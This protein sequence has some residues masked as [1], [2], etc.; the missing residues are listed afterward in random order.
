MKSYRLIRLL[1][2]IVAV[3]I[4]A[5]ASAFAACSDPGS[6]L[7]ALIKTGQDDGRKIPLI[8]IHG[9]HATHAEQSVDAPGHTWDAFLDAFKAKPDLADRYAAYQFQYCS[10]REPV[11][12][13]AATLRDLIDKQ[14]GDR[15]HVIVTHSMGGIVAT[16]YMAETVHLSGSWKGKKGGDTTIGVITLAAPHHG[17]P[18]ANDMATLKKFVPDRYETFYDTLQR[19]YWHA[20]ADYDG[21]LPPDSNRVNRS[22]LRWDNYDGKLDGFPKDINTALAKRD[23]AFEP[24]ASKLI[25]YGGQIQATSSPV[26]IAGLLVEAGIAGDKSISRHKALAFA[27]VGIVTAL[28]RKFGEA[29]GMVPMSSAVFC[30]TPVESDVAKNQLCTSFVRVRRFESGGSGE[31]PLSQLPDANTL[32]ILRSPL[33][34]D[35]FDM[36]VNPDVLKYVMVDLASMTNAAKPS[37]IRP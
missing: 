13:I 27:D 2:C 3:F 10:D 20:G 23:K 28:G 34:Y 16:S 12:E 6:P 25:A 14:L 37:V 17:T 26:A 5:A 33:G 29:D 9:V 1:F 24:Y 19:M 36:L 31:V 35:H 8:L 32:S 7:G 21:N 30:K 4:G 15:A 22:D 18:G 11:T